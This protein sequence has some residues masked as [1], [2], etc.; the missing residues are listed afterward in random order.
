MNNIKKIT[1]IALFS[2]LLMGCDKISEMTS[3]KTQEVTISLEDSKKEF[4]HIDIL[5][6]EFV[7]EISALQDKKIPLPISLLEDYEKKYLSLE[8][9]NKDIDNFRQLSAN[10]LNNYALFIKRIQTLKTEEDKKSA[11]ELQNK[12]NEMGKVLRQTKIDLIKKLNAKVK[13]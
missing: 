10:Y 13:Q 6:N 11:L 5:D 4:K 7:A 12:L 1:A 8:I 2:F 9:K 3:S